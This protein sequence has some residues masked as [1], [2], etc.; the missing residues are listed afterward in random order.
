MKPN[1]RTLAFI[2]L[3]SFSVIQLVTSIKTSKQNV[4]EGTLAK[5]IN[6]G[7]TDSIGGH[8]NLKFSNSLYTLDPYKKFRKSD[9]I[10]TIQYSKFQLTRG[11]LE[12]IFDFIDLNHDSF[13]D[14][15]EW[16][17]FVQIFA[18]PYESCDQQ[19][20]FLLD[21]NQLKKC[22]ESEPSSKQIGIKEKDKPNFFKNLIE[23]LTF[24]HSSQKFNFFS[25]LM[26]RKAMFSWSECHSDYIYMSLNA[27]KCA[28]RLAAPEHYL[29]KM[30][31]EPIFTIGLQLSNELSSVQI[32][33]STYSTLLFYLH[34]F[35]FLGANPDTP[36]L[37]KTSF[38]KA[39][40]EDRIPSNF[41]V[42]EINAIFDVSSNSPME[43]DN[44]IDFA[45]FCFFYNI[46]RLF[47]RYSK[48]RPSL[49]SQDEMVQLIDDQFFPILIRNSIDSSYTNFEA[50]LYQQ[51]R[52]PSH[53]ARENEGDFYFSFKQDASEST[54]IIQGKVTKYETQQNQENRKVFFSILTGRNK[55]FITKQELYRGIIFGHIF[56]QLANE[57]TWVLPI[58]RIIMDLPKKYEIMVPKIGY[59]YR[60]GY[61]IFKEIPI[62]LKVDILLFTT[63][64]NYDFKLPEQV[65]HELMQNI[66]FSNIRM[67]LNDFGMK[68]MPK[69]IYSEANKGI[70]PIRRKTFDPYIF[71]KKVAI[72]QA[73]AAE[74]KRDENIL[75]GLKN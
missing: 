75:K 70:D 61:S 42:D 60:R 72:V 54:G 52:G 11:E 44:Y 1:I 23:S 46:H 26:L 2:L 16:D 73:T 39:I 38:I 49:L 66:D 12:Q 36:V 31:I 63:I 21:Q 3:L 62:E 33:F 13:V 71:I 29:F 14:T 22:F 65:S 18:I 41:E 64:E 48:T 59:K 27:F 37:Y 10:D 68:N 8:P 40:K 15:K 58:K 32:T 19:G 28:L 30:D 55:Q 50:P 24:K 20:T 74:L 57:Y 35:T 7:G 51:S 47:N 5:G 45:S 53:S 56:T 6:Q 25:Y 17:H 34:A 69:E 9:F 4:P 67:M 43:Q